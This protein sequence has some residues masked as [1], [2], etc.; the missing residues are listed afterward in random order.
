MTCTVYWS[1][2]VMRVE[3][4]NRG[5]LRSQFGGVR[6]RQSNTDLQPNDDRVFY[7]E[8]ESSTGVLGLL[9]A[10]TKSNR[11]KGTNRRGMFAISDQNLL[12]TDRKSV[13]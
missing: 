12:K 7:K 3:G 6:G 2:A 10:P 4:C 13:V 5:G 9:Q 8:H 1:T 11:E